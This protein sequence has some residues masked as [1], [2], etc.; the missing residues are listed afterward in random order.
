MIKSYMNSSGQD[1]S[2]RVGYRNTQLHFGGTQA[3]QHS[4]PVA[5]AAIQLNATKHVS[6]S[7]LPNPNTLFR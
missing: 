5:S 7:D 4:T 6:L 3:A 2:Q 1:L